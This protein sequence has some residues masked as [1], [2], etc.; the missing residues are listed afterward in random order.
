MAAN[1][2][3]FLDYILFFAFVILLTPIFGTYLANL[4]SGRRTA[5][6]PILEILEKASYSLSGVNPA[7]EM[8]W[9]KYLQALL[10][11]NLLGLLFLFLI[12]QI[13]FFLPLNPEAFGALDWDLSLNNAISFTSNTDWQSYAG[14]TNL[15]YLTQ[16]LGMTVQNFLSPATGLASLLVLIRGLTSEGVE[17]VGNFWSDLVKTVVYIFLPFS[18]LL[19]IALVSQGV[20]QNFSKYVEVTTLENQEQWIP[21]GPVASQVAIKQLG[22]NGGGFFNANSAHPFENPNALSNFLEN[23]AIMLLPASLTYTYGILTG[24]KK[25]GWMI[26]WVM[27]I[28]WL[29]GA[30]IAWMAESIPNPIMG[31]YPNLEGMETRFAVES[32][33]LWSISTTATTNGSVNAMLSSLTPIGGCIALFFIIIGEPFF[34]GIGTGLISM[35]MYILFTLFIAGLLVGRTPEYLGKKIEKLEM[36]CV[37]AVLIIPGIIFFIGSGISAISDNALSQLGNR[38]PHGLTELLYAFSS[39]M[40]NNGSSFAGLN[41]NSAFFNGAFSLVMFISRL[42]YIIPAI[43]IGGLFA[44]KKPMAISAG[45]FSTE[46][47]LFVILLIAIILLVGLLAFFPA[48]LLG[49][50]AEQILLEQGR[51]F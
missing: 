35:I 30:S 5:L 29:L 48:L 21:L 17:T 1:L 8:T 45:D 27:F 4:F 31:A 39:T 24:F 47:F 22:T 12:Q 7:L 37:M 3:P 44:K 41:T 20:I 14:E 11:F 16:M 46:S 10:L 32:S 49:P 18:F 23:L 36:Q 34:G 38:G 40:G 43:A 19:A 51:A 13:Q 33:L 15:S 28:V 9:T 2:L 6:H 26:F 25:H 50:I 42:T